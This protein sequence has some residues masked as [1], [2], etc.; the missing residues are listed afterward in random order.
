M[1]SNTAVP[2]EYGKFR[3]QVLAGE[4]PVNEEVSEQMNRIDAR[5]ADPRFYYDDQA[6]NGYIEFCEDELT[7]TDGSDLSLLPSFKLWAEDLLAWY[8]FI[9][10]KTYNPRKKRYEYITRK[11]RLTNV[12]YLIVGR[13]AAKTMYAYTIHAYFLTIDPS[14]THQIVVAPTMKQAEETMQPLRTAIVRSR[15]P[16]FKFM[17]QGS[18]LSNTYT[19][20]ALASTKRGIQNFLTNSMVEV[21]AMSIDKL[22]GLKT[23]VNT[24]DEWLSGNTKENVVGAI[25]Q[26]AA[27]T[28]DYVIVA[29]S[30]EGLERDGVGDSIKMELKSILKG[31]YE[32][33]HISIWH[34]KLDDISEVRHPD[35]WMKANP[36]LGATVTYDTYEKEVN[37]MEAV[38]TERSEILAKRFGIPMEG[39]AY[40]F[41]YEDT[42][43]HP[44]REYTNMECSL[45]IDLSQGDDFC[46]FTFLFPL[47][48]GYFGVKARAYVSDV[49]VRKL[50][51]AR[52]IY[53]EKLIREGS[54]VVLEGAILDMKEVYEDIDSYILDND[55]LVS[56]VGYDPW[57]ADYFIKR[58]VEEHGDFGIEVV[59]QG[60][61]TESVPLGQISNAASDR[62]LLFDQELMKFTMGNSIVIEDNNGNLKL[63]KK[64]NEE[65]IDNVS[66]LMDAWV[67]Y[68]RNKEV[69]DWGA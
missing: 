49:K 27:K 45:G 53:Y 40:F 48:N 35:M 36:N 3:D 29:T 64:R 68:T 65:K 58:W 63:S 46:A 8:Y 50:P 11:K 41:K 52:R 66:A 7:L 6:I 23:K 54:L 14:T 44:H 34:Y 15:G 12:Q 61:R 38:P 9:E 17:T 33:D 5:I 30:S 67:A 69:F 39:L 59:R 21:R 57:G 18:I 43:P 62:L 19:K 37:K 28:G 25:E 2:N 1:L 51:K 24:V 56:T 32:A 31:E 20:T 60:Y 4:I 16:L 55:Y 26:G 22:Q 42:L 47:N 13:G 10:E